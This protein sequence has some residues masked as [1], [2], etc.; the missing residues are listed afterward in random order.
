MPM[1]PPH[2]RLDTVSSTPSFLRD[3]EQ[4]IPV[5][6]ALDFFQINLVLGEDTPV[7][8]SDLRFLG[9][10]V[11]RILHRGKE[12]LPSLTVEQR[13]ASLYGSDFELKEKS[14]NSMG[15][16]EWEWKH[17]LLGAAREFTDCL[18]PWDGDSTIVA[19]DPIHPDNERRLFQQMLD[20]YGPRIASCLYTQVAISDLLSG[21][22]QTAFKG[23]SVDFVCAF[24]NG[25]SFILEPGDHDVGA[26][27][28]R[29]EQKDQRRDEALAGQGFQTLRIPNT[30]IGTPELLQTIDSL[31]Q[32]CEGKP[33]LAEPSGQGEKLARLNH[34]VL[35]PTLVAR[36]EHILRF[37][38]LQRGM[39]S[40]ESFR[41]CIVEHDLECA[42]L[43]LFSFFHRLRRLSDLYDISCPVPQI[44]VVIIRSGS[45]SC[46]ELTPLRESLK[47]YGCSVEI[48]KET[49]RGLFDLAIDV[50]IKSNHLTPSENLT[51]TCKATIRNV[52]PHSRLHRFSYS[53]LPR[54]THLVD[55]DEE[56]VASFLKDFFRKK[57]LRDG[58]MPI[59]RN[60]LSQKATIGL[61]PTSAGKSI[62]YQL[63][64]L[65]TPGI[66]FVV[67]PIVFLMQDQVLS[68]SGQFGITKVA[69]WHAGDNITRDKIG[70]LMS[71]NIMVF[72]TP[73]RFLRPTFRSAMNGLLAADLYVNYAVI[74]E[75]HC[76]SM[77]GHEFRPPYLMLERCFRYYCSLRGR[78]PVVVALTGTASQLVLIDLK[79]ELQIEEFDAIVRPKSFD[80]EELTYNVVSCPSGNKRETLNTLLKTIA[81][82]LGVN[83]V[84]SDAYGILFAHR[85]DQVWKLYG[86]FAGSANAHITQI[87]SGEGSNEEIAVGLASGSMPKETPIEGD[88]WKEYKSK[89]LPLFKRG[90]VRMLIGNAA[91]AVGIDN[92]YLN[93]VMAYCTPNSLESLGQQW[94]RAGR[95]SQQSQCYLIFSDDNPDATDQW[96]NGKIDQM[97]RRRDDLGTISYFHSQTFPGEK[98]DIEG[99]LKVISQLYR[100]EKDADGRRSIK[101][102]ANK[103]CQYY[104][105]FLIMMGLVEDFEVTGMSSKTQYHAKFH[106]I[107]EE[108]EENKIREHLIQSL[109]NY[110]SRYHPITEDE[111]ATNLDER[112]EGRLS[113]KIVGYLINF[114]YEQIAYQR[115]ESIRTI[116]DFCRDDDLSPEAI[117][118]RMRAFFDRHPKF[119]DR[120][121]AIADG[122]TDIKA[123]NEIVQLIEGNDDAEHLYWETRRL[124]DERFRADWAA[125]SLSAKMYREKTLSPSSQFLFEQLVNKLR[126]RDPT[127]KQ[128]AFLSSFFDNLRVIDSYLNE[129][130]WETLISELFYTLYLRHKL[131][132][133]PVLDSL[134]CE[135]EVRDFI[136]APIAVKQMG[137]VLNVVESQHGLG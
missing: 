20:H 22:E 43:A 66:T 123:A 19:F 49:P 89:I 25:R 114:I 54:A 128:Q 7:E 26:T 40:L 16:I 4:P 98:V 38:L 58:Q 36:V 35:L 14:I 80:R 59:I 122:E 33:F 126:E 79:R 118:R 34:L 91:I 3:I 28:L 86:E 109:Q 50:A 95:R 134:V 53:S 78:A 94:G 57:Q 47:E 6:G 120:L 29:Q 41:L 102:G 83:D 71:T 1:P 93:Y 73:E 104:L 46:A 45:F 103:R 105:S 74:D 130:V 90:R 77:W 17:D 75:A 117:R 37:F 99:T 5:L 107:V 127:D 108:G 136:S 131:D 10:L 31:I 68:L 18:A 21:N 85:P 65:L 124:L 100:A 113:G 82:R 110:L 70:E 135:P 97:P 81:Q 129:S 119:S 92:E 11:S 8:S 55:D 116:V 44:D 15:N 132:Y 51:T 87:A 48:V 67:D 125:I 88:I 39:L 30:Q 23:Q 121:D 133:L 112:P 101:E 52:F 137:E 56:L 111:V 63:A 13:V 64:S 96:L 32:N 60:I 2:W 9:D 27:P 84:T 42:E 12:T 115:K 72:M 106:P 69:T 62:C 61:L 76:V 24:P